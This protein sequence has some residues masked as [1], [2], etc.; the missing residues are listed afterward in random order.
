MPK[1]IITTFTDGDYPVQIIA[2]G[3][4]RFNV[5]Y[6]ADIRTG[7]NWLEAAHEFGECVFHSLECAGK[8]DRGN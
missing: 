3:V 6:G 8:V 2:T 1:Q 5:V 7:L 4:N